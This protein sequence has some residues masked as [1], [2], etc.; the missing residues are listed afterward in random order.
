MNIK[1]K[2]SLFLVVVLAACNNQDIVY[3]DFS[4]TACYFPFQNPARTLILGK[5]DQGFNENDNNMRFEIGVVMGGVYSNEQERKVHFE[6]DT[7]LLENVANVQALSSEYFTIET[8]SPVTIPPGA[9]D[10]RIEVQLNN[11]FFDDPLSF[12]PKNEVGYVVPIKITQ[13]ENLDTLLAGEPAV[14]NPDRVNEADWNELPRD[15]T[16]FGIKYINEFHGHYLRRGVDVMTDASGNEV[17]NVYHS[18]YVVKDE[19]VMVTTSGRNS[20]T[21]ENSVRRGGNESPGNLTMELTFNNDKNCSISSAEGDP[22][23]VSGSG[24]FAEEADEWG[25]EA[26]D[27][28]YLD[29]TYTDAAN[30]ETHAVKDTL[31]IRDRAVVFEEFDV[32][33]K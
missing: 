5:Y 31:V 9:T 17:E 23:Q 29:Y 26:R 4:H 12:A 32:E 30:N 2:I 14:E 24:Q 21:L 8:E 22:Y 7:A 13:I 1:H 27:V 15:Y 33:L 19:V 16:L 10:G 28:I 18:E 11:A 3:P 20:V 6:L 25:G